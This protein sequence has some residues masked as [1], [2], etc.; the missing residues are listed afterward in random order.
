MKLEFITV[1][2]PHKRSYK[3]EVFCSDGRSLFGYGTEKTCH[4]RCEQA[5]AL[6]LS[7]E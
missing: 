3:W 5:I 7:K 1:V 6:L 4:I 2:R